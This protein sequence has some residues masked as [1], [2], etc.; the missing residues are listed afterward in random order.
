MA[1]VTEQY[2][3]L[4][5][6]AVFETLRDEDIEDGVP[7]KDDGEKQERKTELSRKQP[8]NA[9]TLIMDDMKME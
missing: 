6:S 2:S 8:T 4:C 3:S 7:G 5:V 1:K 9:Q